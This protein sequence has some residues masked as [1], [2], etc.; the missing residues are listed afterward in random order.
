[1]TDSDS[2]TDAGDETDGTDKTEQLRSLYLSVTDG[3]AEPVVETQREDSDRR[4]IDEARADEAV[5]PAE[6]H[7]LDDAIDD[8]EPAD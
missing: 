7:G 3:D 6:L 2:Q 5:G 1:M 8:P 4:E